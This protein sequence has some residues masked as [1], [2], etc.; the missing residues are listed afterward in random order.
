MTSLNVSDADCEEAPVIHSQCEEEIAT[1]VKTVKCETSKSEGD[2]DEES[3]P[4]A[5]IPKL[6]SVNCKYQW[7]YGIAEVSD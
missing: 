2:T 4:C 1:S 5:L 7:H 3:S 6:N